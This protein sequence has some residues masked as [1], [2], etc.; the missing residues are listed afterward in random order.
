MT[1]KE[2]LVKAESIIRRQNSGKITAWQGAAEFDALLDKE[3]GDLHF[4]SDTTMLRDRWD[5]QEVM[6]LPRS[7]SQMGPG[8]KPTPSNTGIITQGK[9][10][11][12]VILRPGAV[13]TDA[14]EFCLKEWGNPGERK[15]NP[16]TA[17]KGKN[18][19]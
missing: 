7:D 15:W 10:R 16:D 17:C 4:F 2:R 19:K 5:G 18:S 11:G 13:E 6:V 14:H 3:S 8:Y 12:C 1:S 9:R